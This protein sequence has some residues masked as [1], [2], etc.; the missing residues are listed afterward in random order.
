MMEQVQADFMEVDGKQ[1]K[2]CWNLKVNVLEQSDTLYKKFKNFEV[3]LIKPTNPSTND[4]IKLLMKPTKVLIRSLDK[5]FSS[6]GSFY[7]INKMHIDNAEEIV[8]QQE[9]K[10]I[11]DG[12]PATESIVTIV[13]TV[14]KDSLSADIVALLR[15]SDSEVVKDQEI[16][17]TAD[18]VSKSKVAESVSKDS[19]TETE[20]SISS[21]DMVA[22]K[23]LLSDSEKR[24][25]D[26][27]MKITSLKIRAGKHGGVQRIF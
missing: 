2:I 10:S 15:P 22:L 5:K 25:R 6:V 8:E 16:I 3:M 27:K 9:S 23:D 17:N 19:E 18:I 1:V 4:N 13:T 7:D 26:R 21:S 12:V 24:L 11:V 14:E 20:R